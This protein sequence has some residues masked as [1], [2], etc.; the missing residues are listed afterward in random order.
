MCTTIMVLS[1]MVILLRRRFSSRVQPFSSVSVS[2]RGAAGDEDDDVEG[3]LN[4]KL[5]HG[6]QQQTEVMNIHAHI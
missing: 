5:T 1:T 3:Q 4:V 6:G 2:A